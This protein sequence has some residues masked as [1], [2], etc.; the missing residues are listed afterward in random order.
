[1]HAG[2]LFLRL[3]IQNL[4]RRRGRAF[5]LAVTVAV[6]GGAVFTAMVLR[7]A[8]QQSISL[9]LSRMGADAL[10]VPRETP[11][12][13][14]AALLTV[15]PTAATFST[16]IADALAQLPGVQTVAP[17]R[18]HALVTGGASHGQDDLIAYDP[19]RDFTVVPWLRDQLDRPLARGDL[20]VGGRR[21]EA[22]G[23]TINLFGQ[24]F[25]VYGR[26]NLTSVGPFERS[27]FA[28]FDTV[29]DIAAAARRVS[30][31]KVLDS[32]PH[33]CSGLLVRMSVG[34]T[35]EQF[36][37]AAARFPEIKVVSGSTL[38]SSVR[39][40]LTS[41]L[42]GAVGL[43]TLMLL[44][45]ALMVAAMYSGLLAER[46]R[47]LGLFLAIGLRPQQMARM[48]VAEAALTT[49]CGGTCGVIL[50]AAG[51]FFFQRSLG[52]HFES[53]Q[54]PFVLPTAASV[55][56]AGAI[57]VLLAAAVGVLGVVVPAWK[58]GRR[59]PYDLV[60]GEG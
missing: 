60:R 32:D 40:G 4:S 57:S 54:I 11:V 43:T 44:S 46:R 38:Y 33:K 41:L 14:T 36:R 39:Q 37:F 47:E 18:Y 12:N 31:R 45:T 29:S 13:L 51:I 19:A 1:M 48:I 15:E 10:V 34:S 23:S 22:V 26:L 20:I 27:I 55:A 16:D 7:Q 35:P 56:V 5:L 59:E 21:A 6:G 50:G 2:S 49:G 28:S 58:L 53:F 30:G 42:S 9:G 8:I 24:A 3:A 25:T 17:Q 52:Y